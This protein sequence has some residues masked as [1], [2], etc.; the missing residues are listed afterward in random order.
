MSRHR[1]PSR[2]PLDDDDLLGEILLRLPPIPS[3]LARAACVCSRWR[4]LVSDPAL[5]RRLR[6]HHRDHLPLHGFFYH[7]DH[8]ARLWPILERPDRIPAWRVAPTEKLLPGWQVLSCS[9]G[10]VLHKDR[11]KFMVL[12]PVAG[13]QHAVPFPSS[14]EDTSGFVLGMVVPSRRSSSYRVVAL[15]AGRSTSTRV[16]AYVYS[17]ESGSWGDSDSPI[18][19]LVLPSKAKHRARHGTIVGSV[20][21]WFLD[22]HKVLTFDL[23][24]QILAII[25]LPPEVV[26]DTDSFYEFRCQIIP[27]LDDGVGEVRLAV[28][29]DPNMQFWERKK[30]GGDGSGAAYTWVLSS[31]VRLNFPS[32]ESIRSDLKYQVLGFDDESNAIFIWVQNVL[33]MVYLRSMQSRKV[34]DHWPPAD[35]FPY[36]SL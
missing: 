14:V 8:S 21:H 2:S 31:T 7:S 25:E 33:F 5:R 11:E 20:I 9:H 16:A 15:F 4:R 26:K 10:L 28:L 35:I 32:I 34:L 17:S 1:S 12:D 29:A 22:G 19:T 23:E 24:R 6:A 27:A 18:A 3:S 13:E 30:T 36:S